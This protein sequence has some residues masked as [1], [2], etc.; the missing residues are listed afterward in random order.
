MPN[1]FVSHLVGQEAIS[2]TQSECLPQD[3]PFQPKGLGE[4]A[5]QEENLT[6][7]RVASWPLCVPC[8]DEEV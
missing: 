3:A 6:H 5:F 4:P 7:P 2:E 8:H 1:Y